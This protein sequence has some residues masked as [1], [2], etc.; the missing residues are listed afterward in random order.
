M[1]VQC[2]DGINTIHKERL[3]WLPHMTIMYDKRVEILIVKL[4]VGVLHECVTCLDEI[5]RI[6]KEK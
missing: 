4:M 1:N 5:G 6:H 3:G 2:C